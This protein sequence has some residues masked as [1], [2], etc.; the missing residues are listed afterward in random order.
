VRLDERCW[1][2]L[3]F[4]TDKGATLCKYV[5]HQNNIFFLAFDDLNMLINK[6]KVK[7]DIQVNNGR[8]YID[9]SIDEVVSYAIT[10]L[11]L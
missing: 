5:V 4:Y 8:E 7:K 11:K 6:P 9:K 2:F 10:I 3:F 1:L